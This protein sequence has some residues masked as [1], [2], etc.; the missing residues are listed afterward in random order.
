MPYALAFGEPQPDPPATRTPLTAGLATSGG[1]GSPT[2]SIT[3]RIPPPSPLKSPTQRDDVSPRR[4]VPVRAPGGAAGRGSSSQGV[5]IMSFPTQYIKDES[6]AAG[7]GPG[8]GMGLPPIQEDVQMRT[9]SP[10][11]PWSCS[12]RPAA[13]SRSSGSFC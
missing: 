10:A 13:R 2:N 11:R 7:P 4:T 1:H 5:K 3:I 12:A 8:Q 9:R 6:A